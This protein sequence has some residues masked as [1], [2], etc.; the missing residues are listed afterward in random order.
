MASKDIIS[1]LKKE[2]L[3]GR[4]GSGFPTGLK[5][6]MV[7]RAKSDKKYIIC[8]ASEGEMK[9]FKDGYILENYPHQVIAGIK[10][11]LKTIDHSS[12]FICLR[13]DYYEKFKTRLKRL[14]GSSSISLFK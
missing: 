1:K 13:K 5:W 4:S 8:N 3:K 11:A 6:E 9:V 2:K 12:A 14:I 10:L 7:K